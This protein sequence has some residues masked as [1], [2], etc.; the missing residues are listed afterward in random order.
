MISEA[1]GSIQ[2]ARLNKQTEKWPSITSPVK[3]LACARPVSRAPAICLEIAGKASIFYVIIIFLRA[4]LS[5][6]FN[7][8]EI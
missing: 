7:I 1:N 2:N 5:I 4:F 3:C 8:E 6:L